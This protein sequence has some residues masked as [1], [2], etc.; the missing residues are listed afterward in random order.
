MATIKMV[1]AM[2]KKI[3]PVIDLEQMDLHEYFFRKYNELVDL[4]FV[5]RKL[6]I[7]LI[8]II[9]FHLGVF[10]IV[11]CTFLLGMIM[12]IPLISGATAILFIIFF[13]PKLRNYI[14]PIGMGLIFLI[15]I[16]MCVMAVD[17]LSSSNWIMFYFFYLG[18][19]IVSY[20]IGYRKSYKK[21]IE[22]VYGTQLNGPRYWPSGLVVYP[23]TRRILNITGPVAFFLSILAI[24]FFIIPSLARHVIL[25]R[26]YHEIKRLEME[27]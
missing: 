9:F 27:S 4:E 25:F 6:I 1:I 17:E 18:A 10:A 22:M 16:N 3:F 24:I 14:P 12:L 13:T 11:K 5:K 21:I 19:T 26:Y 7:A 8:G 15:S 23:V 2:L 20:C